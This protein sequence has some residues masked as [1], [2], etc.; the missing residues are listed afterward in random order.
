MENTK[1][2]FEGY[3]NTVLGANRNAAQVVAEFGLNQ[4][5]MDLEKWLGKAEAEAWTMGGGKRAHYPREWADFYLQALKA[6]EAAI[7]E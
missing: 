1:W 6:L 2:T 5:G 4:T 7:E 3:W